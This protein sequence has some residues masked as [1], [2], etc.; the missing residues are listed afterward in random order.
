MIQTRGPRGVHERVMEVLL[1]VINDVADIL[2]RNVGMQ[3]TARSC[4]HH[5][6]IMSRADGGLDVRTQQRNDT[7]LIL[8]G[9]SARCLALLALYGTR[10]TRRHVLFHDQMIF[11][12]TRRR[13]HTSSNRPR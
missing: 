8:I 12:R 11:R 5:R 7:S 13:G 4:F 1:D 6:L 9:Y 3:S 10:L 2:R